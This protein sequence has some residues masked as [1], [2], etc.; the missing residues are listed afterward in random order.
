M[1][2]VI[3]GSGVFVRRCPAHRPRLEA[4]AASY[5]AERSRTRSRKNSGAI[6]MCEIFIAMDRSFRGAH[7]AVT[8]SQNAPTKPFSSVLNRLAPDAESLPGE[9][10]LGE[11]GTLDCPPPLVHK[12]LGVLVVSWQAIDVVGGN[13]GFTESRSPRNHIRPSP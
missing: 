4:F 9:S 12:S 2:L 8:A 3:D 7:S 10:W 13:F 6:L 1:A 5:S 11:H